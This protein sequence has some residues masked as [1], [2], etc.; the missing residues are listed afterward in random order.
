MPEPKKIDKL[1]IGL[2]HKLGLKLFGIDVIIENF[3]GKYAVIDINPFPSEWCMLRLFNNYCCI[4]LKWHQTT[5]HS[6]S[7]CLFHN[8]DGRFGEMDSK[9]SYKMAQDEWVLE[10]IF[11]LIY[12]LSYV[13]CHV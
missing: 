11:L 7:E 12:L 4:W 9:S 6:P 10:V 2:R 13:H 8:Q 1:V 3:T 5:S